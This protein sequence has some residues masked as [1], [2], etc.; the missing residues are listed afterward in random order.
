MGK[1]FCFAIKHR[2]IKILKQSKNKQITIVSFDRLTRIAILCYYN[3]E[4][5]TRKS[6]TGEIDL[7][8]KLRVD[9]S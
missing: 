1:S 5:R 7:L 3:S 8:E 4:K 9:L 6:I 2:T